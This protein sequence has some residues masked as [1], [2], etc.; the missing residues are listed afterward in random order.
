MHG[1]VGIFLGICRPKLSFFKN[2]IYKN[3]LIQVPLFPDPNHSPTPQ[4]VK[5][6]VTFATHLIWIDGRVDGWINFQLIKLVHHQ[7]GINLIPK[8]Y[9]D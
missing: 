6:S 1:Q 8:Y 2:L 4:S 5:Y 9:H 7:T 3:V